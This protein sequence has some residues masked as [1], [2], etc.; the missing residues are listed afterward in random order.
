MGNTFVGKNLKDKFSSIG[1][2]PQKELC[3]LGFF[4]SVV[5]KVVCSIIAK[6]IWKI[7]S[8]E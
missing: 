8:D 4:A 2:Y 5:T 7:I 1:L 3:L 6:V